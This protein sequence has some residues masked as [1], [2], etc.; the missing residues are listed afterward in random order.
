MMAAVR[1]KNTA[2]ERRVRSKLFAAGYRF[3]LH[4]HDLPGRPDITLPRC[5]MVV[6]VHGCFWHGHD[7]AR[8][9]PPKSNVKFWKKKIT[10]NRMRDVSAIAALKA[11]GWRVG[12]VWGCRVDKDTDTVIRRLQ[13]S[14]E[15]PLRKTRASPRARPARSSADITMTSGMVT[16]AFGDTPSGT[17][18]ISLGFRCK[19]AHND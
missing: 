9:R 11:L 10:R 16:S 17:K 19:G 18:R 2:P 5:R 7:C 8:G 15:V 3:R 1:R 14:A 13:K 6:F 4:R 12:I